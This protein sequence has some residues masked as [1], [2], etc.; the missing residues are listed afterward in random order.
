MG[1]RFEERSSLWGISAV[2]AATA[3]LGY[4][5]YKGRDAMLSALK[6]NIGDSIREIQDLSKNSIKF[7]S[8]RGSSVLNQIEEAAIDRLSD[9]YFKVNTPGV[10]SLGI[11][12]N[13]LVST[14]I[15]QT[16]YESLLSGG[17]V[18]EKEALAAYHQI[19][20][21]EN[22]VGAY[23]EAISI[24]GKEGSGADFDIFNKGMGAITDPTSSKYSISR[25]EAAANMT[26]IS[27]DYNMKRQSVDFNLLDKASQERA[28]SIQASFGGGA[29]LAE[30]GS[31]KYFEVAAQLGGK[32]VKT[33]MMSFT[34]AG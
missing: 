19:L 1:E 13:R 25:L 31:P 2:G 10:S 12:T 21:Q 6:V 7:A 16:A 9:D 5:L 29:N 27:N 14:D 15:A 23:K 18:G 22:R 26:T 8:P 33:P 28:Q 30:M 3:G 20:K 24:I 32:E 11:D 4:S 17:K 34:L